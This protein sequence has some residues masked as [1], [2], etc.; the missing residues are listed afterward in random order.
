VEMQQAVRLRN[1]QA[2][3]PAIELLRLLEVIYR[4]AGKRL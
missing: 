1:G 3:N 4:K 2:E